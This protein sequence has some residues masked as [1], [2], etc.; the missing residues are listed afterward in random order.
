MF[1]LTSDALAAFDN[2]NGTE[3]PFNELSTTRRGHRCRWILLTSLCDHN[4]L[5]IDRMMRFHAI[6][7]HCFS[8][9]VLQEMIISGKG[10]P[11]PDE[12]SNVLRLLKT[13][14]RT[15]TILIL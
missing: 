4:V 5:R 14:T 3:H 15:L 7:S 9:K 2:A 13:F 6:L 11:F 10:I 8:D 1:S 12:M